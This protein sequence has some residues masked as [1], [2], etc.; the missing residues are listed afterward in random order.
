MEREQFDTAQ[1]VEEIVRRW[2]DEV[3]I[4]W[5]L[6]PFAAPVVKQKTLRIAICDATKAEE[7]YRFF[8][9]ELLLLHESEEEEIATTLVVMPRLFGRFVSFLEFV[10]IVEDSVVEAGLE[11]IIQVAAFHPRYRFADE[12]AHDVSHFAGRAPFAILHLLREDAISRAAESSAG[13]EEIPLRNKEMLRRLGKEY[14]EAAFRAL[15]SQGVKEEKE[16][17]REE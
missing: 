16:E 7:A 15:S 6:C 13:T 2:V 3:V 10:E 4:G 1:E 11:G 5:R 8:L 9:Q 17:S 12:P 14:V